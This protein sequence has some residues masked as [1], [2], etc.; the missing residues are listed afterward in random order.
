MANVLIISPHGMDEVLGCGGVIARHAAAGD[1]VD[2]LVLFGDGTGMDAGR[3]I[4]APAAAGILGATAPVFAGLPENRSDSLP[5]IDI[6]RP[7]EDVVK[8]L[9]P[10]VVYVPHGGSLHVDHHSAFRAA[11]TA[12]RPL[13]GHPAG[14]IYAYEIVS[15]TEWAPRGLGADIFVPTRF[16][17]ISAV[18]EKKMQAL[19]CYRAEMRLAP[20]SRSVEGVR[21]LATHRGHVAGLQA[22]EAFVTVREVLTGLL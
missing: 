10:S 2:V 6:I 3:R 13:P 20:H 22:A 15:S 8:R 17:D 12:I 7:I 4:A 18:L 1:R 9:Q 5:L 14:R 16:V 11:V 21:A 19:D